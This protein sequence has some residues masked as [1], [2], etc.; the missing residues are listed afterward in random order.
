MQEL[1]LLMLQD[2]SLLLIA[3]LSLRLWQVQYLLHLT[4]HN[5]PLFLQSNEGKKSNTFEELI[6]KESSRDFRFFFS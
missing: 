5:S 4:L 6:A 1:I 3:L 2:Q